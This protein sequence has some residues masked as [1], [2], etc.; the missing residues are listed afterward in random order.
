MDSSFVLYALFSALVYPGLLFLAFLGF[1]SEWIERKT[2]ARAQNRMGPSYVG[3]FGLLQPLVDFLKLL[4]VKEEVVPRGS[5]PFLAK[6]SLAVGVA[7]LSVSTL[8][9]PIS[10][11]RFEAVGDIVAVIYLV[12]VL[13]LVSLSI[14][15]ASYPNPYVVVGLSRFISIAVVAE[16]AFATSLLVPCVLASRL[17]GSPFTIAAASSVALSLLLPGSLNLKELI[18]STIMIIALVAAIVSSQAKLKL[19]PFDVVEAEQELIAGPLTEMSGPTLAFYKLFRNME[20]VVHSLLIS[21]VLL[22]GPAPYDQWTLR[23][24]LTAFLKFLLVLETM[25]LIRSTFGR[26][27]VEDVIIVVAKFSLIPILVALVVASIL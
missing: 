7:S 5:S 25:I 12:I 16:P 9:L 24:V 8:L 2:I 20:I 4:I 14:A 6:A 1:F 27:R 18:A 3:R 17:E 23:G 19:K 15:F 13:P 26:V 10:P 22:G 21:Y 11:V